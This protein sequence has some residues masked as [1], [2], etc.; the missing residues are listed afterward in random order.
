MIDEN[1]IKA[2]IDAAKKESDRVSRGWIN[3]WNDIPDPKQ[4]KDFLDDV[5]F[6]STHTPISVRVA[7]ET[8]MDLLSE[9]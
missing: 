2:V 5:E 6:K 7:L 4:I 3:S 1:I 8:L 9:D